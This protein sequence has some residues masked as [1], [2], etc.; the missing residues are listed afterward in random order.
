MHST[1]VLACGP[2][3]RRFA[4]PTTHAAVLHW[5][6]ASMVDAFRARFAQGSVEPQQAARQANPGYFIWSL[7][8]I[9]TAALVLLAAA[10]P[11]AAAFAVA[12]PGVRWLCVGWLVGI[13]VLLN[14]LGRRAR[15][16]TVVLS[17][18]QYGI[19]DRRLMP[20]RIAWQEIAAICPVDTDRN[21]TVDIALSWPKV[22]LRETRWPV[23]VG[24]YCQIGCGVPAVTISMLL[25]E[26]SVS[27]LLDAVARYRPDLLHGTNR[28]AS[29]TTG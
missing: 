8:K 12:G 9:R 14:G 7:A 29:S 2:E 16:E 6:E 20:R 3:G 27:D 10:L 5:E 4:D 11:A 1:L 26:G 15:A 18:D 21:H 25:L 17:V 13:A 19:L 24:A 28:S 23:R 22:T